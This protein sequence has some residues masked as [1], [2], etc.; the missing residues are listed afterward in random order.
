MDHKEVIVHLPDMLM[1]RMK[2]MGVTSPSTIVQNILAWLDDDQIRDAIVES[3]VMQ[4]CETCMEVH[5]KL[6]RDYVE[7]VMSLGP[8]DLSAFVE[9]VMSWVKDE[10]IQDAQILLRE[11]LQKRNT[12]M[13]EATGWMGEED[14]LESPEIWEAMRGFSPQA[15]R[16]ATVILI[17]AGKAAV[18]GLRQLLHDTRTSTRLAAIRILGIIA[19][20]MVVDDLRP[21]L[22]DAD[23]LI[24]QAASS[25]LSKIGTPAALVWLDAWK[26]RRAK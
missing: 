13:L 24:G 4:P 20:P 17:W 5:V 10:H 7:H 3:R 1:Y 16:E 2:A 15:R 8:C 21:L 26:R 14:V 23:P 6:S 19:D 12:V 22:D 25:A 9:T 11:Q 18:P